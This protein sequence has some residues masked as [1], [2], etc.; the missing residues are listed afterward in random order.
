MID[1]LEQLF[2]TV[3]ELDSD[4]TVSDLTQEGEER[5]DSLAHM[6]L[7]MA[8]ESEFGIQIDLEEAIEMT[9]FAH[10]V[11]LVERARDR[12]P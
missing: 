7:V 8:M 4:A 2:R 1:R 11:Q 12:T 3:L 10:A 6:T 9:S 5:W